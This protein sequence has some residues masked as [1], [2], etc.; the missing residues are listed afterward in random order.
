MWLLNWYL[1]RTDI[2][3]NY[4]IWIMKNKQHWLMLIGK[5]FPFKPLVYSYYT[6]FF[7]INKYHCTPEF[8]AHETSW[9]YLVVAVLSLIRVW[10][11]VTP[12]TAACPASL[13]FTI[14][15]SLLKFM[16]FES[17]I[18]SKNLILC[19]FLLFLTSIFPSISVFSNESAFHIKWPEYLQLQ[20]Q[21]QVFQWISKVPFLLTVLIALESKGRS[22]VFSSTTVWKHHFFGPHASLWSSSHMYI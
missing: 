8:E 14:S 10:F 22:R 7:K 18:L 19:H 9:V 21:H 3:I 4:I 11:S 6:Q 13:S 2:I 1:N 17:A 20:L 5:Q 12:Q 15:Q 16:S